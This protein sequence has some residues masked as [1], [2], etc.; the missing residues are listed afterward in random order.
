MI[1]AGRGFGK[2]R[3]GAEWVQEKARAMPG[4]RGAMVARTAAD[5]RDVMVEG[6][7]G[8]LAIAEDDFVPEYRPG[9]RRLEWPN[10]STALLYSG[11]E[12][13]ALRGPA[14]HWAWC[15][16]LA[17]W[18][19]VDTWDMLQ[20]G[21]RLGENPQCCIT[22]TPRPTKVI[23]DLVK[24]EHCI[25]VRG[26]TY[27]N[28]PNL[29]PGFFRQI[30]KKYEGTRLG[31]QE[32]NAE[33]LEDNPGALWTRAILDETR[34]R[35]VPELVRIVV[36]VDPEASSEDDSAETGII[37]VGLGT[38]GHGYVLDDCTL[39]GLPGEWG[40]QAVSAFSRW[41]ANKVVGEVNNGG[42]M[43]GYVVGICAN[44]AGVFVPYEAKRASHSKEARADP[45]SALYQQ[46][47]VH[48]VGTYA[49]L[50]DQLTEWVPGKG[51]KSPDRLDAL[52]W[53]LTDLMVD[54]IE[55]ATVWDEPPEPLTTW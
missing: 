10:G 36:G 13:N 27:D 3:S 20:F 34:V 32:L 14:F 21:L 22:T 37:V 51:I 44:E 43:V 45:V 5:V 18:K 2:S 29:A 25:V 11:E 35:A 48:H 1:M 53:A 30:I 50:E 26:S 7:S 33:L 54:V 12:P 24:D 40:A 52:V 28:R 42:E 55:E 49:E 16:E 6:V 39:R 9:K 15:D 19:Y 4:S 17:A 31:R 47:R 38:D 8:I 23:K 41:Q 46:R